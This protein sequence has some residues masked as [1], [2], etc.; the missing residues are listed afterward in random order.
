M[1][2][3]GYILKGEKWKSLDLGKYFGRLIPLRNAKACR[4][5]DSCAIKVFALNRRGAVRRKLT[6]PYYA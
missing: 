4:M 3:L 6:F 2:G 5:R 1:E